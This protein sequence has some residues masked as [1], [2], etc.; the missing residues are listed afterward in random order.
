MAEGGNDLKAK[1]T[2]LAGRF[3]TGQKVMM[4]GATLAVIVAMMFVMRSASK[5][6]MAPLYSSLKPADAAA[7][8][9]A[10]TT[11][12]TTYELAD[13]GATIMV[14]REKVYDLR[15]AMAAEGLPESTPEGYALLDKQGITASEFS[16]QVGFQRAMEGELAK[17]IT[18]MDPVDTS[19]VHLAIPKDDVFANDD[20]KASASVL[21]KTKQGK[22]LDSTQ[23][24]AIVHLVASSIEGL[25]P[26]AVTV[27]DSTGQ[28]LAAPGQQ[29][30]G[31]GGDANAKQRSA[32][33]EA[34]ASAIQALIEPVVGIGKAKVTV[35]AD[36]DYS[37]KKTTSETFQQPSGDP[38]VPTKQ[39]ETVKNETYT[40]AGSSDAGVLGPDGA[41]VAGDGSGNQTNYDLKQNDA[42][43]LQNRAVEESTSAPGEVKRLSVAVLVD[44]GATSTDQITQ[45]QNLVSAAA[46]LSPQRG[47][48]VQ[49]SRMAF[50]G[51]EA[52]QAAQQKEL[53]E[54]KAAESSAGTM[55][56]ARQA[57]VVLFLLALLFFVYRSMKKAAK[58]RLPGLYAGDVRELDAPPRTPEP[59]VLERPVLQLPAEA[60][61]V[62]SGRPGPSEEELE[63]QKV[64]HQVE[65]MIDQQPAEVAQMLRGWLDDGKRGARK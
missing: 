27:A 48:A 45:I 5:T 50:G 47:D 34:K 57:A 60:P 32:F 62:E 52:A 64:T 37:Q 30:G 15:L 23:V 58:R 18:A 38:N 46:G 29:S 6:E 53:E 42:K 1:V 13:G 3:T 8:T 11:Q 63:R 4:V 25:A 14:P 55:G 61:A 10:L 39:S 7:V 51:A 59:L 35:S 54:A 44:A 65:D 43:F 12:G 40:G 28:V 16:Q 22:T 41:P 24:Q 19:T 2:D 56:M 26:E 20:K 21:V 31:G 9:E 36:L 49:V 33:E 17:T